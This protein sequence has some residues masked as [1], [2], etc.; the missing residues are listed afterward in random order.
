VSDPFHIDGPA[1]ISFSGGKTS[2]YMLRRI[3]DS[4]D[5]ALPDDVHVLF[6]NTGKEREETLAFVHECESRWF[7]PIH[8]V[9]YAGLAY[10][11]QKPESRVVVDGVVRLP[12]REVA[13]ET[14]ARGGEPFERVIRER[15]YLPNPVTRFCT[16]VLKVR[17]M[18]RWMLAR[19][20]EEWT[21]FVGL[22][23][24]EPRRVAR[25]HDPEKQRER[26]SYDPTRCR[27][28][29]IGRRRGV[30]ES[31]A[32]HSQPS[33]VGRQLRRVFSQ[34]HSEAP[35]DHGGLAAA[36]GMV[37]RPRVGDRKQVPS[38]HR[39]LRNDAQE[40]G[41]STETADVSHR[42]GRGPNRLGSVRMHGLGA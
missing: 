39:R 37:D 20:H 1:C 36:R 26:E 23:A 29:Y 18:K 27:W 40:H 42:A 34:G 31:A 33:P 24:D 22:R 35:P 38:A 25:I 6:A 9:E 19:G 30:L 41:G 2:G 21:S 5:G 17:T 10:D 3:L 13:Y 14:A 28:R 8:W 15:A 11:D 4:H 12:H 7:V 16:E 32:V